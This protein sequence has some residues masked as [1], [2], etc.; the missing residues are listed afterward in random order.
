MQFKTC[1]MELYFETEDMDAFMALLE[2]HPEVER[3]HDM[4][5][6]PWQQRGI[7]LFDPDGHLI[8]VSEAMAAVAFREF[9]RGLS[10]EETA[11]LIQH[12]LELVQRWHDMHM[13][14]AIT[15]A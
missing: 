5:T 6:F 10:V 8:E 12:P 15:E 3:L 13:N 14:G 4:Q 11:A 9:D 2:K 7:R 1:S